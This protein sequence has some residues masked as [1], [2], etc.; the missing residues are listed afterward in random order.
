MVVSFVKG[1]S[2]VNSKLHL[3]LKYLVFLF[4][5]I[6]LG[7]ITLVFFLNKPKGWVFCGDFRILC[8]PNCLHFIEMFPP[9][10]KYDSHLGGFTHTE[11][12]QK[13][14]FIAFCLI[15]FLTLQSLS[16][17]VLSPLQWS[18]LFSTIQLFTFPSKGSS[19]ISSF[20]TGS[21]LP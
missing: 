15:N 9:C 2:H 19:C 12:L 14:E 6:F 17:L 11:L 4:N 10:M 18:L 13:V 7:K 20:Y 1:N 8:H 16:V 3:L 21:F 5:Q